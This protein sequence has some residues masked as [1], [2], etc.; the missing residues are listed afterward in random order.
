MFISIVIDSID[1]REDYKEELFLIKTIVFDLDDTLLWDEKSVKDAFVKTCEIA[2]ERYDVNPMELEK[3]VRENAR[4]IYASYPTYEFTKTIGINPFEGL[5]AEFPEQTGEFPELHKIVFEYR[6]NSWTSGLKNL[7]IDDEAFGEELGETFPKMRRKTAAL[8]DDTLE[9]L[10]TLKDKYELL[11][12]TN[13]S[14]ALQNIKL[15]LTPELVG[16]FEEIVISG[17]FGKGKPDQSIFEHI[18]QLTEANSNEVLMVGDNLNTDI[19]GAFRTGI[20]SV[21]I[22]RKEANTEQVKP[23]YEIKNLMELLPLLDELNKN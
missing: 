17:D 18:L 3:S 21:W 7:G 22:N 2:A 14:P 13:G 11:L 8:Y 4:R 15:D 12:L 20:P 6:K 16:Y 1:I 9:L 19:L 5:W 23:N 10:D